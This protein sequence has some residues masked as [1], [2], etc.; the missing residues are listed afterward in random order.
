[1]ENYTENK[2]EQEADFDA[3]NPYGLTGAQRFSEV[4]AVLLVLA[5]LLGSFL[6]VMFF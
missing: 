3:N 1:M 6:K 2:T 4:A 5:V